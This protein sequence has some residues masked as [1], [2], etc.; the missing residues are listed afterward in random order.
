MRPELGQ[1]QPE[2]EISNARLRNTGTRKLKGRAILSQDTLMEKG[3]KTTNQ[4]VHEVV[5]LILLELFNLRL[6]ARP[7]AVIFGARSSLC[8]LESSN[9]VLKVGY[10]LSAVPVTS[11]NLRQ[12][13]TESIPSLREG[14][15]A[16]PRAPRRRRKMPPWSFAPGDGR[17]FSPCLPGPPQG[18]SLSP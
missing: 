5:G 12:H 18:M 1:N 10:P 11:E 8:C 13:S 9:C 3:C 2:G 6:V 7:D 16:A 17:P 14:E 4:H 15:K